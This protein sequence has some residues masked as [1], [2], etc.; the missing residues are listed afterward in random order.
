[1]MRGPVSAH[2]R[3]PEAGY[4]VTSILLIASYPLL[5]SGARAADLLLMSFLP[6]PTVVIGLRRTTAGERHPWRLLLAALAVSTA[7]NIIGLQPGVMARGTTYL[8]SAC[9]VVLF[10]TAASPTTADGY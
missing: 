7:A 6:I 5:P 1:M 4:L 10:L 9:S 2:G 3:T 8:L